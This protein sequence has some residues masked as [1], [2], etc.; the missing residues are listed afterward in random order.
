MNNE[1]KP[2]FWISENM[3]ILNLNYK[4]IWGLFY[5]LSPLS[6]FLKQ[7]VVHLHLQMQFY[8]TV[9]FSHCDDHS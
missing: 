6:H 1:D 8:L 4:R 5:Q 7:N 3:E 9:E 2:L